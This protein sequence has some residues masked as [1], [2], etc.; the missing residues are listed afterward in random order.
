LLLNQHNFAV[1]FDHSIFD[2]S[3]YIDVRFHFNF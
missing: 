3:I 1:L 2:T